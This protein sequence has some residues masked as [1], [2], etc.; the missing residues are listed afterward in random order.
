MEFSI[1]VHSSLP[2][3]KILPYL[4]QEL[5]TCLGLNLVTIYFHFNLHE[6]V[7]FWGDHFKTRRNT[8]S[9]NGEMEIFQLN[10]LTIFI[11]QT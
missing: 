6:K 9:V 7:I 10:L 11:V 4:A 2:D 1:T 3:L 5:H 8:V